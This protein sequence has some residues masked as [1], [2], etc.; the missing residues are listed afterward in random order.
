MYHPLG[1][2]P[3]HCLLHPETIV[4]KYMVFID[5]NVIHCTYILMY[6]GFQKYVCKIRNS[7]EFNTVYFPITLIDSYVQFY[8]SFMW[9]T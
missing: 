7:D 6:H 1:E 9:K 8:N 5:N 2:P 3:P 4:C